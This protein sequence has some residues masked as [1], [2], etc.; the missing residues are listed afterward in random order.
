MACP[1]FPKY[2]ITA[3]LDAESLEVL[4]VFACVVSGFWDFLPGIFTLFIMFFNNCAFDAS[5]YRHTAVNKTM[6]VSNF[7]IIGF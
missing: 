6:L 4:V 7:F 3:A 2:F 5:G 1:I